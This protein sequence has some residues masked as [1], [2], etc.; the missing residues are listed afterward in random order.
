VP[1]VPLKE[2]IQIL[3]AIRYVDEVIVCETRDKV[4]AWNKIHY[5]V[6]FQGGDWRKSPLYDETFRFLESKG[7]EIV[8]F[9]YTDTTS[10]TLLRQALNER[11]A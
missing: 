6:L 3:E 5:D 10:S 11:I 8:L 4:D 9:P 2:R 7:A 1:V